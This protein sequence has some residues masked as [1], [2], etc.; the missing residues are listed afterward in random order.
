[1]YRET[2][3]LREHLG[4][5]DGIAVA[6]NNLGLMAANRGDIDEAEE[7]HRRALVVQERIGNQLAVA[8]SLTSLGLM[9]YQRC[10]Y[11][12][13]DSSYRRALVILEERGDPS[14]LAHCQ[15]SLGL[16]AF[17]RGDYAAAEQLLLTSLATS[18]QLQHP[19][20][21]AHRCVYLGALA[22]A[23]G[24]LRQAQ[25]WLDRGLRVG[26]EAGYDP[27]IADA[28]IQQGRLARE[29][30]EYSVA[31][32][33]A[34]RAHRLVSRLG[35]V[36]EELL[37]GLD[38]VRAYIQ[39]GNPRRAVRLFRF[40][41]A[42]IARRGVGPAALQAVLVRGE[43][44]LALHDQVAASEAAIQGLAVARAR[45]QRREEGRFLA[46]LGRAALAAGDIAE[47]EANLR[48]AI[49]CLEAIGAALEAARTRDWLKRGVSD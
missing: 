23:R 6:W 10:D 19:T 25:E 38:C 9:A 26:Q 45:G 14:G 33:L 39:L 8:N 5:Q 42:D 17:D 11:V 27:A 37:T 15:N 22:L 28:W 3:A 4:D 40:V 20:E 18:E 48:Q 2:L 31:L 16:L 12:R 34:R 1:C 29:Q 47:G 13:A 24:E 41:S 32:R 43:L 49:I 35:G 21:A 36:E 7:C 44:A 30:G 46:M